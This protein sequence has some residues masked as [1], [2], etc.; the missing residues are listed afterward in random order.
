[1]KAARRFLEAGH[2]V[3]FTVRF[4]G[5]E[6]THPEKAHEQLDFVINETEDIANLEVARR[7]GSAHDD[8]ARRAEAR[9]HAEGRAGE[10]GRREGAPA[11]RARR[12]AHA[13]VGVAPGCFRTRTTTTTTNERLQEG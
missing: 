2:K 5:R 3:K 11:G 8:R 12:Q 7:D 13:A 9:H 10:G 6:I 1:M 4:R